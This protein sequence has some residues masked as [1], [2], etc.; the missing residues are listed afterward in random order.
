MNDS[1]KLFAIEEIKQLKARYFRFMDQKNW[2][3]LP[4]VFAED[5]VCD[6]GDPMHDPTDPEPAAIP[7]GGTLAGRDTVV[8]FMQAGLAHTRSVHHGHMAEITIEDENN[9]SGIIA[10]YDRLRFSR[11]PLKALDG[12]GHYYET[13][14]RI[15][16]VWRIATLRLVR[17]QVDT[18]PA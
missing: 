3:G 15:D 9:A 7:P 17:L 18:V 12:Y 14:R 6:F 13:Y 10:M 16:G 2:A 1:A 8:A 11:G 4:G 5:V